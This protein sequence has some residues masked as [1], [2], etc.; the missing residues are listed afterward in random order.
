M[1]RNWTK[2]PDN[3]TLDLDHV[4]VWRVYLD[5][6][7]DSIQLADSTLSEDESHRAAQF[8]FDKDRHRFIASHFALRDV[9]SRYL[10]YV[11]REIEFIVGEYGKP[12]INSNINIDFNLSHSGDYALIAVARD[13]KVGVDVERFRDNMEH[14]KIAHRFFSKREIAELMSLQPELRIRG[15]YNCW[16]RK[17]AYIKAH[18]LG[19]SLP[20]DSFDVSLTPNEPAT[21]RATRPDPQEAPRWTLLS[22]DI[23]TNYACA[24]AVDRKDLEFRFWDW[25]TTR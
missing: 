6:T 25:R 10:H 8:R 24:V 19:L 3:L 22:L 23:G 21:L 12:A 20:L 2:S 17:E 11:P 13:H 18:G 1:G 16:T 15:F 7:S 14:E 4:D 9:L 5:P